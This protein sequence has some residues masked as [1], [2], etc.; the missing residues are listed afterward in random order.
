MDDGRLHVSYAAAAVKVVNGP[1]LVQGRRE[2]VTQCGC[3]AGSG[4]L[5]CVRGEAGAL[6]VDE[7]KGLS[8]LHCAFGSCAGSCTWGDSEDTVAVDLDFAQRT[9]LTS[10]SCAF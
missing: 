7:W 8:L 10:L 2:E 5:P 3:G 1:G 4:R 6:P 9:G